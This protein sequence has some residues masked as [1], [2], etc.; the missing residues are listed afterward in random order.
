MKSKI[1]YYMNY[2]TNH[3]INPRYFGLIRETTPIDYEI[4]RYSNYP[5]RISQITEFFQTRHL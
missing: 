3:I 4:E 5:D 2:L 1:T